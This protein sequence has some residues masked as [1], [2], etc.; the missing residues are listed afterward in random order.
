MLEPSPAPVSIRTSCPARVSSLAPSGVR[1]T[2][3]SW[4]LTSFGTPTITRTPCPRRL[5]PTP[6]G[7]PG[8]SRS[9]P[10]RLHE[11]DGERGLRV[12]DPACARGAD[13][14]FER[15]ADEL[16]PRLGV[17]RRFRSR[18]GQEQMDVLVHE[19]GRG[20]APPEE[21]DRLVAVAG[22]LEELARGAR[23]RVLAL[24][25]EH[26]RGDLAQRAADRGAPLLHQDRLVLW[27][28]GEH[29]GR[30]RMADQVP[31]VIGSLDLDLLDPEQ[32]SLE[33]R[34]G[35]PE[36]ERHPVSWGRRPRGRGWRRRRSAAPER[37]RR[38]PGTAGA[39]SSAGTGARGGT[40]PPRRTDD[41]G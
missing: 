40:D 11:H 20:V 23:Q 38:S 5:Q 16:D 6:M 22:L 15:H 37:R 32:P 31:R 30:A 27:R 29:A 39:G 14:V 19:T 28:Q 36:L 35:R 10:A 1:A 24:H 17:T 26:P 12:P 41:R 34:P 7:D 8:G 2:R 3:Y 9:G 4:S 21:L 33:D 13:Q 18:R 25:V